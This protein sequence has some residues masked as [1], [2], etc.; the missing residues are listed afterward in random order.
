MA[1]MFLAGHTHNERSKAV[2]DAGRKRRG[3]WATDQIP[4]A[5]ELHYNIRNPEGGGFHGAEEE[6]RGAEVKRGQIQSMV[7]PLE[8]WTTTLRCWD[9]QTLYKSANSRWWSSNSCTYLKP[10]TSSLDLAWV[11]LLS[12][13]TTLGTSEWLRTYRCSWRLNFMTVR[14]F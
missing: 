6:E 10:W 14:L 13:S 3:R 4:I 11:E 2:G 5:T 1:L 7:R 9:P 12:D 8:D